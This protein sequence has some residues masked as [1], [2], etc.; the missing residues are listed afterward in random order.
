MVSEKRA[1]P[2]TRR[3]AANRRSRRARKIEAR[4]IFEELGIR[5]LILTIP[6]N[7]RWYISPVPCFTVVSA[8]NADA[9]ANVDASASSFSPTLYSVVYVSHFDSIGL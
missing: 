8:A 2:R 4:D 9:D 5:S 3:A 6:S 7:R 1:P